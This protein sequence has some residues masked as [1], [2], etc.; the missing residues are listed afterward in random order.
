MPGTLELYDY[1]K[2]RCMRHKLKDKTYY[3]TVVFAHGYAGYR[4][5]E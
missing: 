1:V 2:N 5:K 3:I 4:V